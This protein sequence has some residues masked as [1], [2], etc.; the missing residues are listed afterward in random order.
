MFLINGKQCFSETNSQL[1]CFFSFWA[2]LLW[3]NCHSPLTWCWWWAAL[4]SS[5]ICVCVWFKQWIPNAPATLFSSIDHFW[6]TH[7]C[8]GQ[9]FGA[10]P[11][12]YI[13]QEHQKRR[14]WLSSYLQPVVLSSAPVD[15]GRLIWTPRRIWV[16]AWFVGPGMQRSAWSAGHYDLF[17]DRIKA[18]NQTI[19]MVYTNNYI[20]IYTLHIH[21][22]MYIC[23]LIYIYTYIYVWFA[24]A[25]SPWVV[26]TRNEQLSVH[27]GMRWV[28]CEYSRL[29]EHAHQPGAMGSYQPQKGSL[30]KEWSVLGYY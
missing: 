14:Y 1:F 22:N 30:P 13:D 28:P 25:L 7:F 6:P 2:H 10:T 3:H 17:W 18:F 11:I 4:Q 27:L 16:A 8:T 24:P 19:D 9:H 23:T 20:Y 15:R 5:L 26:W 29:S 21:N 12:Y